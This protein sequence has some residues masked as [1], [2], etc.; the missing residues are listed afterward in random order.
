MAKEITLTEREVQYLDRMAEAIEAV[1]LL[2]TG[3][4]FAC[5]DEARMALADLASGFTSTWQRI[6]RSREN[7]HD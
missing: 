4:D 5:D 2:M 1:E 7:S 6:T 3:E